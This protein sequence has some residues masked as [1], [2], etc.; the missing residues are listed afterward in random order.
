MSTRKKF[1]W[2]GLLLYLEAL[3]LCGS[4]PGWH[5]QSESRAARGWTCIRSCSPVNFCY[6]STCD[7]MPVMTKC[8]LVLLM[9]TCAVIMSSAQVGGGSMKSVE[10]LVV[11]YNKCR[12]SSSIIS[13]LN[14]YRNRGGIGT[15]AANMTSKLF[16]DR[17]LLSPS[18]EVSFFVTLFGFDG[19]ARFCGGNIAMAVTISRSIR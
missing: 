14:M 17:K 13:I 15:L 8:C 6:C 3:L 2:L 12:T 10:Q 16:S 11:S 7:L 19:R 9:V 18:N 4:C 1:L 5:L